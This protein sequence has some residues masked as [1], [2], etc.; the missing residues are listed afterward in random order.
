MLCHCTLSSVFS[1][2]LFSD[3]N[4]YKY[5]NYLYDNFEYALAEPEYQRLFLTN[6]S[7]S[8]A[9]SRYF[10]CNYKLEDY[11]KNARIYEKYMVHS[12]DHFQLV[13]EV[14]MKS[15][16]L[17]NDERVD[18]LLITIQTPNSTYNTLSHY[19]LNAEWQKANNILENNDECLSCV[20]YQPLLD[21]H[22][23][24]K[25]KKPGVAVALSAVIPGA[26]KAYAG[27]WKDAL[28]SFVFVSLSAWQ[29]YRGF[30]Q[31]GASSVYGWLYGGMGLGFYIGNVFG[32]AKAV[33]KYNYELNH[34]LQH[35]AQDIYINTPLQ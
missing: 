22:G 9:A 18:S 27:Y 34:D 14:Y 12:Q 25:Y 35:Q 29:S 11:S 30:E 21:Q 10:I 16:I 7:D 13:D 32:S 26:G 15:L 6:T 4:T 24:N 31:K 17:L 20:L 23:N 5:A 33:N 3:N 2:D 28:F 8:L 19:M 1:Q